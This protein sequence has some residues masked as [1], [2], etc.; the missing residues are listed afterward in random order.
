MGRG[1][2]VWCSGLQ[3]AKM[4]SIHA[5]GAQKL[6]ERVDVD[7]IAVGSVGAGVDGVDLPL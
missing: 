5:D 1:R 3:V 2:M 4:I 7:S 6:R